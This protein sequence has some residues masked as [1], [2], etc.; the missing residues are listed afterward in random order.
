MCF[1]GLS[2]FLNK[3]SDM[4]K[5]LNYF[6]S[7]LMFFCIII[8][9][10]QVYV[11]VSATGV[12]DGTSWANA[13]TD[14]SVAIDMTPSNE[15]LWIAKGTY[16]PPA[17]F[18]LG[19][20]WFELPHDMMLFGGFA[21][22]ETA[23]DQRD[24]TANPTIL[25]GDL[26]GDDI[27]DNYT[28]NKS[29]NALHVF[30]LSDT[31][32]NATIFDGLHFKY[33]V[34]EPDTSSG[35]R[36]RGGGMLTY[37]SPQIKNCT[38]SQ[39]W[40][41]FGGGLYPRGTATEIKLTNCVF[42]NNGAGFGAGVYLLQNSAKIENC[43]FSRNTC[44]FNGGGML[45][46]SDEGTVISNCVFQ[47]NISNNDA[48]TGGGGGLYI[49]NAIMDVEGCEFVT[50]AV[51]RRR[52]AGIFV[53]T[54]NVN[55]MNCIFDDNRANQSTGG[56]V[57]MW[58]DSIPI[59]VTIVDSEFKNGSANWG[60]AVS[61]YGEP[62][63]LE[64]T[65]C[66][67]KDNEVIANGG[68]IYSGFGSNSIF[69]DCNFELNVATRGGVLSGQNDLTNFT[70]INCSASRN[71]AR[72]TG[73]V[74]H[75]F[76]GDSLFLGNPK[77]TIHR[78]EFFRNDC[79]EQGGVMNLS[80]TDLE[81][82]NSLFNDNSNFSPT[83]AGG[84]MSLNTS[85]P[86]EN[87]YSLMNNTFHN[88]EGVVGAVIGNWTD[89]T[90]VSELIL[91][92]NIFS[93]SSSDSY[94][95]EA[96]TPSVISN[97]G[98]MSDDESLIA[99]AT[100]TN[101]THNEAPEF[102]SPSLGIFELQSTSPAID[103]GVSMG[104]PQLDI[105]GNG[106]IDGAIDKGAYEFGATQT[107]VED[108]EK[109]IKE[110]KVFPNPTVKQISYTLDNNWSGTVYLEVRTLMGAVIT[111]QLLNKNSEDYTGTLNVEN[112]TP[113]LYLLNINNQKESVTRSFIKD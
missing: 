17:G 74:V 98:N 33:G 48:W 111:N 10:G 85:G 11:D 57:H 45:A 88:N 73:G 14:L 41:Y 110:L 23:L 101:D 87:T 51:T 78:S 36:R 35:N 71:E 83:G 76:S 66:E 7:T 34:T 77:L 113:G 94:A 69:A 72:N 9:H 37:G 30:F 40:G 112:L 53:N 62:A 31:I 108:L 15:S 28:T 27:D 104:A 92:N 24:I 25:S 32:T 6:L 60:A 58:S 50:N 106:R 102:E 82:R 96:G 43:T 56:G 12:A 100:A 99:L 90:G 79:T 81:V 39:N 18:T 29:D 38:F 47:E 109:S 54:S 8:C 64:M 59:T 97:G 19:E 44:E 26:S 20:T 5:K 75:T 80:D 91:Q 49:L 2:Y 52:G 68:A 105:N 65:N 21:G 4:K 46:G 55:I 42:E 93:G 16:T 95:I 61:I 22:T 89:S 1:L 107:A 84:V 70:L 67:M 86:I 13:Y 3:T 103:S 63:T